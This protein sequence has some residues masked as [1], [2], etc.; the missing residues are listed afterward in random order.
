MGADVLN[1]QLF[2]DL[3]AFTSVAI[4]QLVH[5]PKD[6]SKI[7]L[8][9]TTQSTVNFNLLHILFDNFV[10]P[11]INNACSNK[12]VVTWELPLSRAICC[13]DTQISTDL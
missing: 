5:L 12:I 7:T 3:K 4:R 13:P 10:D 11:S 6:L 2:S 8:V 1:G 9:H